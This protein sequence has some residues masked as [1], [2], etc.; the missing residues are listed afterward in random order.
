[1]QKHCGLSSKKARTNTSLVCTSAGRAKPDVLVT[2]LSLH[3]NL[4]GKCYPE[5]YPVR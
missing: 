1:M 2:E 5:Q 3:C 4:E